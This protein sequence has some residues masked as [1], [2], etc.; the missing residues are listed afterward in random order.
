MPPPDRNALRVRLRETYP[1]E[2]ARAGRTGLVRA[3]G[4]VNLIGEHTDYNDG[5]V[6]PAAIDLETRIA[7]VP[8]DDRRVELLLASDGERD[9]FDLDA[10]GPP[11]ESWIDTVAGIAWALRE[12][13]VALQGLRGV[14]GTTI[15]IGSGLSSSAALQVAS[16]WAMTE[17]RPPIQPMQLALLAQRAEN[18]YVGVRSG[19]M[20]QFASAH[21]RT[22]AALLLDCRSLEW[23]PVPLPLDEYSVVICDTRSPRKLETSQYNLRRAQCEEAV[24][25]IAVDHPG[26]RAL[27][28]VT[29]EMLAAT[30]GGL[31]PVVRRRA[32]HVVNENARVIRAVA[33]LRASD[34]ATL[35]R[36]FAESHRSLG[37]LYEVTSAELDA[38]VEIAAATPGV[39]AAR[40]TGAGFGGCTVNLVRHDAI[41]VLADAVAAE[42]PRR[43]GREAAVYGVNLADGAG[44]VA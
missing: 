21:G 18:E 16:A 11:R 6:L 31:D 10:I 5:W 38:L 7:Y 37:E 23:E 3:P 42:Y 22:N 19:V 39:A 32:D 17:E 24:R 8:S 4:R 44:E 30:A 14:V 41:P 1:G 43:I 29:P 26:V 12:E 13:G 25:V 33:A 27:R 34:M 2:V 36:L 35:G 20:D 9:G 40:M 28:D 15:P